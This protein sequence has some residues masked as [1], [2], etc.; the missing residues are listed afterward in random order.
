[1]S[2]RENGGYKVSDSRGSGF[3]RARRLEFTLNA[4][5]LHREF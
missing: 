1:M 4:L 2:S 5:G 3:G